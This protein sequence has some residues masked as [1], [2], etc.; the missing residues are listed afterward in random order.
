[1]RRSDWSTGWYCD[2]LPS[3]QFAVAPFA[4]QGQLRT[5]HGAV[6]LPGEPLLYTVLAPDGVQI[7]G[8]G[9]A[10]DRAWRWDGQRW[11][12]HGLAFGPQPLIFT[13]GG[14]RIV[15]SPP[16]H[17]YRYLDPV[18]GQPVTCTD[19]YADPVRQIWEYTELGELVIG[20]GGEGP[21]GDDPLIALWR[22]RRILI[23]PGRCRFIKARWE[24]D[25]ISIAWVQED[26]VIASVL[27]LTLAELLTFP[28]VSIAPPVPQPVPQPQPLPVPP[29]AIPDCT[30]SV[31]RARA[32][33]PTPLG[34]AHGHCLIDIVKAIKADHPELQ[35]GLLLKD[36][37]TH[38]VLPNGTK[39][40]QDL[41]CFPDGHI[42]D[43]LV[44]GEEA[45]SPAWQD[46]GID[47]ALIPRYYRVESVTPSPQPEP[48]P[49]PAPT[50]QPIPDSEISKRL[51]AI[52]Q[53]LQRLETAGLMVAQVFR[54]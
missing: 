5:S 49:T 1:V 52:E 17:G 33:Y 32:P 46:K 53:R 7:A 31:A 2:A 8:V 10:T 34:M 19:T 37:G 48:E 35:P 27:W 43:C 45:A 26:A 18:S 11:H 50:P 29:M 38:V 42:F 54:P 51:D 22:G 15:T 47:P 21:H 40:S 9:N 30:E 14:L 3:G 24:G 41:I 44:A 23:Q 12:D 20:Q 4:G 28:D 39:V 36:A 25:Q 16:A 6:D 13:A